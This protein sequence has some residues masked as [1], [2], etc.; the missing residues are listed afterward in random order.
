MNRGLNPG[1]GLFYLNV[2]VKK[3]PGQDKFGGLIG[4]GEMRCDP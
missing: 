1:V 4:A 2:R 3:G